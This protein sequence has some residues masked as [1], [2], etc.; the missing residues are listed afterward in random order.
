M[1][2]IRPFQSGDSDAVAGM[3]QKMLRH[4]DSPP[5]PR[6]V[7]CFRNLF[8]ESPG[9]DPEITSLVHL[10]TEGKLS[11][12][13]GINT[14]PMTFRGKPIRAAICGTLM[15]EAR[16]SDPMAGARLMRAFLSGPQDISFSE[17]ASDVAGQM[18]ARLRG[19]VLPQYSLEWI[20]VIRPSAFVL[21]VAASR[22]GALRLLHPLAGSI[23]WLVRR[24]IKPDNPHWAGVAADVAVPDGL[25]VSQV[26]V[27][28][29]TDLI[30]PLTAQFVLRPDWAVDQLTHIIADATDKP[31]YG[32]PVMAVVT[33]RSGSP[34]GA[35]FYHVRRDGIARVL[36]IM[37]LPGQAGPVIDCLIADAVARGAVGLRGRTQPALLEAMLTR[38]IAFVQ[39]ASTVV[40]SRDQDLVDAFRMSDGFFNGLAGEHWCQLFGGRFESHQS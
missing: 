33:A 29:F 40:H 21:D 36:Q 7:S 25:S 27:A 8:L 11:G 37:A 19:V 22:F 34:I 31:D 6:L 15:V 5:P 24:G 17:T 1:S 3:F 20:R 23:D 13:I 14:L 28:G 10:N 39:A 2:E 32:E 30:E 4:R 38:R 9:R 12:F 26:D 35:Y 18:W 16:E